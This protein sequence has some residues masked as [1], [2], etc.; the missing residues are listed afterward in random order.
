M[1]PGRPAQAATQ[2]ERAYLRFVQPRQAG[3]PGLPLPDRHR[4]CPA[5]GPKARPPEAPP[6][7]R[8]DAATVAALKRCEKVGMRPSTRRRQPAAHLSALRGHRPAL[9]RR[10]KL[11]SGGAAVPSLPA[12]PAGQRSR[13]CTL[14]QPNARASPT[15]LY[16]P[17]HLF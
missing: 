3:P 10:R 12:G 17:L 8:P 15:G 1:S 14:L 16:R 9:K 2:K 6:S 7:L 11:H 4:A 5:P 13:L